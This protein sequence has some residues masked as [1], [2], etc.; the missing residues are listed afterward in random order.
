MKILEVKNLNK[1]FSGFKVLKD[2]SMTV[3]AGERRGIIGPNGA[4]K[5]TLFN[6]ISGNL[7][8]DKGEVW[9]FGNNV[10]HLLVYQRARMG[11]ARTFQK[12][13]L[14]FGLNLQ[15]NIA[16]ALKGKE[17]AENISRFLVSWGLEDKQKTRVGELS[18]GEQRQIEFLLAIVQSP[19]LVLLD[20]PTA[21]MSPAE[22]EIIA[23][24]IKSLSREI[25]LLIIEHDMD[26]IF[27]VCDRVT[28]LHNGEIIG[29]GKP[30]E[31]KA[32]PRVKE[33]YLGLEEE[34]ELNA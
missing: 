10:G 3:E 20:E 4:G 33:V 21:G 8:A 6:I 28:I 7:R 25:T 23:Q 26:I 34:E 5:T 17:S 2:V 16:L 14:F 15:D 9:I 31:I 29:D 13:T 32:N 30:D 1:S 18:Y 11:M 24:M 27:K 22:T 19:S 12:N